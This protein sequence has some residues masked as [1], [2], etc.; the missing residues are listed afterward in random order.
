M[1]MKKDWVVAVS[2]GELILKGKNRSRFIK[3]AVDHIDLATRDLPIRERFFDCGKYFLGV[4]E[5]DLD[6][7]MK[8]VQKVFG[9][10][11]ITPS[12]RVDRE[13]EDIF[14]AA[15]ILTMEK[16]EKLRKENP[17]KEKFTFKVRTKRG[18]KSYPHPSPEVSAWLGG[19]LL[20][21]FSDLA[22]DVH[23]PDFTLHVEIRTKAFVYID[24]VKGMGGLP[25]GS[26]GRGLLLLSGG[27]D[28]PAAGFAI[29]RRGMAIGA[30]HF[31][32]YPYT[33]ERAKDKA[34]R[35]AAQMTKS[36]GPM[37]VYMVNILDTYLAC[38]EKCQPRNTTLL[39]RRMMMRIAD[40]LCDRYH[41]DAMIT[42]ESLGQ[43]ASQTIQSISVIN[44]AA[45]HPILR[46]FIAE[47]KNQ[48]IEISR[49][50]G[51][52]DLS[53]LPYEDSCSIF[54]PDQPNTKPKLEHILEDEKKLDLPDLIEKALSSLTI[55]DPSRPDEV[56]QPEKEGLQ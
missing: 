41:Y 52:Y 28:S 3:N 34:L 26:S 46:P 49:R 16:L 39:S 38:K 6:L 36:V 25:W 27:I 4:E 31:H 13:K 21:A 50:I 43:V 53:I 29:A 30:V 12:L 22:V 14:Q 11:Y 17:E 32:A 44:N 18:D 2:F 24:R 10:V 23:N 51:T 40:L 9:L 7:A 48:I 8:G 42:G 37:R 1:T 45:K 55:I 56:I 33:S 54:A 35:L 19:E 5:K 47:D 20:D 15:K